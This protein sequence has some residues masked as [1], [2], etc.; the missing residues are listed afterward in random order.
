MG[1]DQRDHRLDSSVQ[2]SH[3]R[4]SAVSQYLRFNY[5]W[6]ICLVAILCMGTVLFLIYSRTMVFKSAPFNILSC[7][8]QILVSTQSSHGLI[9]RD[10]GFL[11]YWTTSQ[12]PNF[13]IASPHIILSILPLSSHLR[14]KHSYH[15]F[16]S[17]P[18][19]PHILALTGMSTLLLTSMHVQIATRVLTTFPALYWYVAE[20]V[21]EDIQG[22]WAERPRFWEG[23]VRGII[24]FGCVGA[25]L[26]SAFLPPA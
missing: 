1:C 18:L 14:N 4:E 8:K 2:H 19:T 5:I 9:S 26:F 3:C 12:L 22:L 7:P 13:L 10:V 17:N 20:K 16:L 15:T 11:R 6:R 21:L 23:V 25:V 24:T